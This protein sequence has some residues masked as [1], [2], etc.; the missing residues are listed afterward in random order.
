MCHPIHHAETAVVAE[1]GSNVEALAAAEVPRLVAARLVVDDN[2]AAKRTNL[3]GV[4]V[5]RAL[6]VFP[7]GHLGGKGRFPKK[8]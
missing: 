1:G 4:N 8:V 3:C 5:E 2:G 7:N 6:E